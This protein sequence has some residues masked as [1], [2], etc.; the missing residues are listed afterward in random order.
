MTLFYQDPGRR[1]INVSRNKTINNCG[2]KAI[3]PK[4][5]DCQ[6]CEALHKAKRLS[7]AGADVISNKTH[8]SLD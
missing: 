5:L 6:I 4:F 2:A 8:Y 1:S 3:K 7:K